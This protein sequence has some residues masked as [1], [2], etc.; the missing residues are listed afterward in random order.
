MSAVEQEPDVL[1]IG[2]YVVSMAA[3][4]EVKDLNVLS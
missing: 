4:T 2:D 3:H 1:F